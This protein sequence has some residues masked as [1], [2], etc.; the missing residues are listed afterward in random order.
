MNH[1][2]IEPFIREL[3]ISSGETIKP[4]FADRDLKVD[5]KPD[6]S[7]VTEADR[8][9]EEIMRNTIRR[10]Y[11]DHGI[12]GEEFGSENEEATFVW[13]LDPIDG[14]RPFTIGCP[15]FGT[16]ICL[17]ERGQPIMGA[18]HN[19]VLSQLLIGDND[20]TTLNGAPVQ[21][22][23]KTDLEDAVLLASN[24]RSAEQYQDG[25]KW[26][27][28]NSKVSQFYTWGDCYGYLLVATGGA[29]IMVDP[30]MNPWDL[31]ALIPIIRGAGGV[32]TDWQGNDPVIGNSIVAANSALHP[33]V[34]NMLNG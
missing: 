7:P 8:R 22:G 26:S 9:A 27:A 21:V 14:T 6:E 16:L 28:L 30:I 4:Y 34:I 2:E 20:I 25:E 19:P 3:A 1:S 24:L 15:L 31:L 33:L 11:P 32:I 23:A 17:L 13:V 10:R 29:D 12:I 5:R 18:I